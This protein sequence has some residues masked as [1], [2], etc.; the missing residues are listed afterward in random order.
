M[1][2]GSDE[3]VGVSAIAPESEPELALLSTLA[4]VL[5]AAETEST[6]GASCAGPEANTFAGVA[7]GVARATLSSA[8]I[9]SAG[10]GNSAEYA[11][12][13][14]T[15]SAAE[16]SA[17]ESPTCRRRRPPRC[18]STRRACA[19]SSVHTAS[20]APPA[21]LRYCARPRLDPEVTDLSS[22]GSRSRLQSED[23]TKLQK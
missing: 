6:T 18:R 17:R 1:A 19:A 8:A 11:I 13:T 15:I 4:C 16:A 20:Q 9:T 3:A 21:R 7:T 10:D 5:L 23:A 14:R 22:D 12:R 2:T